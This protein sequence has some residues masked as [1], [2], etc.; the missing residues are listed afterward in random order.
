MAP[1][2]PWFKAEDVCKAIGIPLSSADWMPPEW[3]SKVTGEDGRKTRAVNALGLLA[4]SLKAESESTAPP[5]ES[6]RL[7]YPQ[8]EGIPKLESHQIRAARALMEALA[9]AYPQKPRVSRKKTQ[10]IS[11]G[12]PNQP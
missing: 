6:V 9:N 5:L 11:E 7:L 4:L 1:G 12:C 3:A 10:Q 8:Y 2:G